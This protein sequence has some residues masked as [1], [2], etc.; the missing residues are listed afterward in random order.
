MTHRSQLRYRA[1][2]MI[3]SASR[4]ARFGAFLLVLALALP[5][6][7]DMLGSECCV[8]QGPCCPQAAARPG[9]PLLNGPVPGCCESVSPSDRSLPG[10]RG[11]PRPPAP[12]LALASDAAPPSP[13]TIATAVAT[14]ASEVAPDPPSRPRSGRAPPLSIG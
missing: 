7:A 12:V 2:R 5:L 11:A 3:A 4:R 1:R 9:E 8:M 13:P 6:T 10:E 14:G